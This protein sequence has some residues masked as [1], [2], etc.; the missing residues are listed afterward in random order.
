MN[1]VARIHH[2]D[3]KNATRDGDQQQTMKNVRLN[4]SVLFCE[5]E[6]TKKDRLDNP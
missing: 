5:K 3:F 1:N 4:F 6:E 2:E